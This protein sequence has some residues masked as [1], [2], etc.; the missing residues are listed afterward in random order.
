MLALIHA[1]HCSICL[2]CVLCS[3]SKLTLKCLPFF[4]S[5]I[6]PSAFPC[7][8]SSG[9]Q[10][11]AIRARSDALVL[12]TLAK[13]RERERERGEKGAVWVVELASLCKRSWPFNLSGSTMAAPRL[14]LPFDFMQTKRVEK[15]RAAFNEQQQTLKWEI[16]KKKAA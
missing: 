2:T 11:V 7:V 15:S 13:Q 1:I 10:S 8:S 16:D 3:F 5:P 4:C 6:T 14:A 9:A 12:F